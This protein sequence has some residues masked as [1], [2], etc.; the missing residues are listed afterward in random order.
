SHKQKAIVR[1]GTNTLVTLEP[2]TNRIGP[3]DLGTNWITVI[4]VDPVESGTNVL[5]ALS[6]DPNP[7]HEI[8]LASA[9]DLIYLDPAAPFMSALNLAFYGAILFT[10]PIIFFFLAQF[11]LPALKIR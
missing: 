9:T 3:L 7:S 4:Q 6:V 10:S 2:P 5:L 11:I 1:F 8:Q